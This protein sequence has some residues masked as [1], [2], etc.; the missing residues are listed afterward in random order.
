MV[1]DISDK[2]AIAVASYYPGNSESDRIRADLAI[3]ALQKASDL[4]YTTIIVDE[5]STDEILKDFE[6]YGAKLYREPSM[7]MGEKRREAI[8]L[9]SQV[10]P[11]IALTE[12]EKEDYIDSIVLTAQPILE[13]R[14]DMVFPK[15]N[16]MNSYPEAQQI[17]E[18]RGN[19]FV[20]KLTG[21]DI[22]MWFGPRTFSRELSHFFLEYDEKKYG[23]LQD[24][25]FNPVI[26]IIV[27]NKVVE[28]VL[29]DY[30]HPKEQTVI[31]EK[32]PNFE[33]KR[34]DQLNQITGYL[35][36]RW[37]NRQALK[38]IN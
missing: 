24:S 25:F 16:S 15:R 12:L 9:A 6:K 38:K 23:D 19:E 30:T 17:Y 33:Q 2:V 21:L 31:E 7:G 10:K 5:G 35:Q 14:A 13:G 8:R 22:D 4:Y 36:E 28:S 11:I 20:K 27:A 34:I 32:D 3:K 37:H 26:D 29:I 18:P 1:N